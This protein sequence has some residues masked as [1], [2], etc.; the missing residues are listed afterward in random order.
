M[1]KKI[2][3]VILLFLSIEAT[4][5]VNPIKV[6]KIP[7]SEP[8]QVEKFMKKV[9]LIES[10]NNHRVVNEFG[11]MGK[12]QFSPSTVRGLGYK[13]DNKK[14]LSNSKLQDTVMLAYMK[15]NNRELRHIIKR[16]NGKVHNGIKVTR[17]GILAGAHF[18][19]S[20][21][22]VKYFR[23]GG[24]GITDAR[25]TTVHKYMSY[26]STFNLPEL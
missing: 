11:M 9:A 3:L 14:F 2:F 8:S 16:Y 1:I 6:S 21:G 22:V 20:E 7:M 12:Y 17:A 24:V 4:K 25:G 5:K 18:A 23:D 10:G 19:G 13:V 26:F 15:A